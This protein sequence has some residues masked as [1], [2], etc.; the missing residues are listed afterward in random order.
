ML[1]ISVIYFIKSIFPFLFV[2]MMT[3]KTTPSTTVLSR[4]TNTRTIK[5]HHVALGLKPFT[6]LTCKRR[7]K[8]I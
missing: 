7:L 5:L 6:R 2:C 1:F 8:N 3:L 4:T